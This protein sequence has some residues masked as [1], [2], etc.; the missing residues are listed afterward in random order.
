MRPQPPDPP[1]A[2]HASPRRA[3][4]IIDLDR[5]LTRRGTY[6]PFLLHVAR[7]HAPW[8]LLLVPAVLLAMIAYKLRL[9]DRKRL[10]EVMHRL[11]IGSRLHRSRLEPI[12]ALFAEREVRL[13]CFD[14][15]RAL[16]AREQA[17]GRLVIVATAAHRFYA[18][19]LAA[20]L[21]V[22]HIVATRST[23]QDGSLLPTI[24]GANC[25]G[26]EKLRRV[27][28]YLL[29][30]GIRPELCSTRFY[31]DDVSDAPAFAWSD[32]PIAVNPSGKLRAMAQARGWPVVDWRAPRFRTPRQDRS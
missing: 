15:G 19:E 4:S 32:E 14:Q 9:I 16:I 10:K 3:V 17:G 27:E 20:R 30:I 12:V 23:W 28:E 29:K 26:A 24:V 18:K 7:H 6:S 11:M 8:R 1:V 2:L 22:D 21:G 13:N 5:T 25:H 31:S